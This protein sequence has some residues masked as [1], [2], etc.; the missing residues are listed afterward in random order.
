MLKQ[1]T[2]WVTVKKS[3][4]GEELSPGDARGVPFIKMLFLVLFG[5]QDLSGG[6]LVPPDTTFLILGTKRHLPDSGR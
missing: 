6:S 3:P 2:F 5:Q 1:L 4:G